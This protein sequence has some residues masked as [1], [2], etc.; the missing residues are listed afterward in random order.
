MTNY[1]FI[2]LGPPRGKVVGFLRKLKAVEI[3]CVFYYRKLDI[4]VRCSLWIKMGVDY[5][6]I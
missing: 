2:I 5:T 6:Q 3:V 4:S 1:F